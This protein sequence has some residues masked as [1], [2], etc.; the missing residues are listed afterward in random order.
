MELTY[1][2]TVDLVNLGG[3]RQLTDTTQDRK[4]WERV[5]DNQ[6][7]ILPFYVPSTP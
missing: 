4:V 6:Q 3:I 2:Y 1:E 5:D 7:E